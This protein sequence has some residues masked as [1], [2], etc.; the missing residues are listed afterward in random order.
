M[1]AFVPRSF[2]QLSLILVLNNT[3]FFNIFLKNTTS[4]MY[5]YNK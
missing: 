3:T 2:I 4:Y 5:Y 1:L